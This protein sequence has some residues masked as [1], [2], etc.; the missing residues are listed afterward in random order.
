MIWRPWWWVD[1]RAA[2]DERG[3]LAPT[4]IRFPD[5]PARSKSLYRLSYPGLRHRWDLPLMY[6]GFWLR[7]SHRCSLAREN[8]AE[9]VNTLWVLQA[10][11]VVEIQKNCFWNSFLLKYPLHQ[12]MQK[13]C[14]IKHSS[15]K[16]FE[17]VLNGSQDDHPEFKSVQCLRGFR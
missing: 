1:L 9:H 10:L 6:R 13:C 11:R 4:G 17:R 3:N 8:S 15:R 14:H 2:T 7:C 12:C 5:F 16:E